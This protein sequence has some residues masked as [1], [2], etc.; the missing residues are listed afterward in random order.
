MWCASLMVRGSHHHLCPLEYL[1]LSTLVGITC[2]YAPLWCKMD[3]IHHDHSLVWEVCRFCRWVDLLAYWLF[4]ISYFPIDQLCCAWPGS[5][6]TI[7]KQGH[8]ALVE[9]TLSC[10]HISIHDIWPLIPAFLGPSCRPNAVCPPAGLHSCGVP[11]GAVPPFVIQTGDWGLTLASIQTLSSM[12]WIQLHSFSCNCKHGPGWGW[13]SSSGI[14]PH[15]KV[16]L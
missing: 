15:P 1:F 10:S 13:H 4:H 12:D 3:G 11:C 6:F 7:A 9:Y 14:C 16:P 8:L 5:L 2:S